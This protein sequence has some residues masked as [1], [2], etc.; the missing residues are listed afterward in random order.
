[1]SLVEELAKLRRALAERAALGD[2][3]DAKREMEHFVSFR[4]LREVTEAADH[5]ERSGWDVDRSGGQDANSRYLL[6][7]YR[8]QPLDVWSAEQALR[9]VHAVTEKHGGTYDGFGAVF[10]D[11]EGS[12]PK[13]FFGR[14]FGTP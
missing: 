8:E 2:Q 11:A 10:I 3:L 6:R 14:L 9:G 4:S 7:V 5:F 1:M 13:G 12:E